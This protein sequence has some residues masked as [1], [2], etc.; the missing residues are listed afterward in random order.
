MF[1]SFKQGLSQGL[2]QGLNR[3]IATGY[4]GFGRNATINYSNKS[5]HP[6]Y[7]LE[8][9]EVFL[10]SPIV[11]LLTFGRTLWR[12]LILGIKVTAIILAIMILW[13]YI[14]SSASAHSFG[15]HFVSSASAAGSQQ[16]D[17]RT[18]TPSLG[19]QVASNTD[20]RIVDGDTIVFKGVEMRLFGIDAPEDDQPGGG[21]ASIALSYMLISDGTTLESY[22]S[23][24]TDRYGRLLVTLGHINCAMVRQ[25]HAWAYVQYSTMCAKD[26]KL[27]RK[28]GSGIF[29]KS[30]KPAVAPWDWRQGVRD[31]QPLSRVME[32]A[33]SDSSAK[34]S[35]LP[36]IPGPCRL[37]ISQGHG[38]FVP[39]DANYSKKR[40]ADRDGIACEI[41]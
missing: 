37:L 40:D 19:R 17:V 28:R 25:G 14:A 4:N 3:P 23:H 41:N 8:N 32:T 21:D 18:K 34:G 13:L 39:G 31:S 7:N 16:L 36:Y 5:T 9:Y 29:S 6:I 27:A 2:A 35:E 20:V 30:A 38:N 24:G 11:S 33:T 22:T 15:L 1:K 26:E 10:R 12:L